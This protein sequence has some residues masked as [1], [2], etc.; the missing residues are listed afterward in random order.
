LPP[1]KVSQLPDR[2]LSSSN[3]S[4]IHLSDLHVGMTPQGWMWPTV[5]K[6]FLEDL[7]RLLGKI[8]SVELVI[9]S[10]DLAQI[11]DAG[12][13]ERLT[14]I[15]QE[16]WEVIMAACGSA[17]FLF[18]VPGNH[19][20][21]RPSTSAAAF[22]A[23]SRWWMDD[24]LREQFWHPESNE[25][26]ELIEAAFAN[27]T[28]WRGSLRK[29]NIPA[30]DFQSGTLPGDVA[31]FCTIRGK[32]VGLIGLNSA[33]LQLA[34]GDYKQRLAVDTRQLHNLTGGR[35]D[36][37]CAA[38]DFN[39]LVTHHPA[40]WLHPTNQ[41][42]WRSEIYLPSRF[43]CHLHGHMH[44][45]AS[46]SIVEGGGAGRRHIQGSSLFGLERVHGGI[47][48]IHGYSVIQLA[49]DR[50]QRVIRQWPR[51]A[52][53]GVDGI[54]K[55]VP[56]YQFNISDD[57]WFDVRYTIDA[58]VADAPLHTNPA[59][60]PERYSEASK[61]ALKLLRRILPNNKAF[62]E[63]RRL[64]Q[65]IAA[66]ALVERRTLW[67]AS[68]WGLGSD[69]FIG[70]VAQTLG[71]SS[72]IYQ[73]DCAQYF[74]SAE[75]LSGFQNQSGFSFERFCALLS[76]EPQFL[77][78][79]DDVPIQE[80][81]DRE[82]R[83]LQ[84]DIELIVEAVLQYCGNA[85]IV[86][87]SRRDP[88]AGPIRMVR[89]RPLDEADTGTYVT[90]HEFGGPALA[91]AHFVAQIHRHTDGV[92]AS[93]D[94]A[95]RDIQIVGLKELPSLN[96]DVAG[97]TA[98]HGNTPPGL[99]ATLTQLQNSPDPTF[100]RSWLLLK[101]LAMFP[102]GEQLS[103]VKRFFQ[104]SPF[105]PQDARNLLDL[106]L[107]DAIEIPGIN[108]AE[109]GDAGR[110][111]FVS[112]SV[113]EFL[114][115]TSTPVELKSLNRRALTLYF[116]DEWQVKGI[117]PPRSLKF[118]DRRCGSWQIGNAN[119]L[120][121]RSAREAAEGRSPA[122]IKLAFNLANSYCQ[123]LLSGDHFHDVLL[124][125]SD[126]LAVFGPIHE[127]Q[128]DLP[129]LKLNYAKALRMNGDRELARDI[130]LEIRAEST[131]KTVRTQILLNL[132][133][134]Y[135]SL[136]MTD[137]AVNSAKECRSIEPKSTFSL[138]AA[139]IIVGASTVGP[140]RTRGLRKLEMM[141]RKRKAYIVANNIA[142]DLAGQTNDMAERQDALSEIVQ[143]APTTGDGYNSMR[144][145]IELAKIKIESG[146]ALTDA[147]LSRLIDAYHYLYSESSGSLLNRCHDV[148]W[149][150]FEEKADFDNLLRLF[151]H[152]SLIWRLRGQSKRE[153]RCLSRIGN[154]FGD[155]VKAGWL[156]ANR[157][158]AYFL[159]RAS[160]LLAEQPG[161]R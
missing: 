93:I 101:V 28:T 2:S 17:P 65:G 1:E 153:A 152:S 9:F 71:L 130:L 68:D 16:T 82:P 108:D 23:L 127:V 74:K 107:V 88:S 24:E 18:P 86:V 136:K 112:R 20:L 51:K 138:Q 128:L 143:S 21:V 61:A 73:I 115:A 62:D 131:E 139:A 66:S 78:L 155:R 110:A 126:L 4:I 133:L 44:E 34:D 123:T 70:S 58:T 26:Q 111:L 8:G 43:D 12:E 5:K 53:K 77:L 91:T 36:D 156:Q 149:R 76:D 120:V 89:L 132:S 121:L 6:A 99:E 60:Q 96:T 59:L 106:A 13:Y 104:T 41:D 116:G 137:E 69:Q 145:A 3:V 142:L 11:A 160:Q 79:L 7:R 42:S 37:W 151:R 141:A 119:L 15:L 113:R 45:A 118:D 33:W 30:P 57:G 52:I 22:K 31:T 64:E 32:R 56:D 39:I 38:N 63:V 72:R 103:T 150:H 135:E 100:K 146:H 92:P 90:A 67:V 117:K 48:R 122:K 105:Y 97:K 19:D 14:Q 47:A 80:S 84:Q 144:A 75:F 55:I 25:Y 87:R 102:R 49:G 50:S 54:Y 98:V 95:L 158:V 161:Q 29:T 81:K 35:P 134:C 114:Y 147:D 154:V 27:Y 83:R 140:E 129:S 40:S 85:R 125:C 157:E 148:L 159:A 10:G 109:A 124:L 94:A 46:T